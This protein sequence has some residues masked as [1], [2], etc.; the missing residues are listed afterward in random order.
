MIWI[1]WVTE[2]A[3]CIEI[4]LS[5]LVASSKLR[6]FSGISKAYLKGFF[7]IDAAATITPMIYLQQNQLINLLKMLRFAHIFEMFQ[8]FKR[9]IDCIMEGKIARKRS[10][11]LHIIV[12]VLSTLLFGHICTCGWIALGTRDDGW[13]T[14]LRKE[15]SGDEQFQTYDHWQVYTLASYWVY[16]VLTTVGY[17]DYFG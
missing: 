6:T 4:I 5:F 15:S 9:L 12:L 7:V 13:I 3:W 14:M 1:I 2:I 17:G 8:P 16:T 10:D 11:V